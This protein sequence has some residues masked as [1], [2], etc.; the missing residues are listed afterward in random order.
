MA[1]VSMSAACSGVADPMGLQ[2]AAGGDLKTAPDGAMS[3]N[4]SVDAAMV[5]PEAG[6]EGASSTSST[7]TTFADSAATGEG[8]VGDA[9]HGAADATLFGVDSPGAPAADLDASLAASLDAS[10]V[11]EAGD[12]AAQVA[13]ASCFVTFTVA[14]AFIDGVLDTGVAIGGDTTAL[15]NWDSSGAVSMTSLGAGAWTVSLLMNDGDEIQ[16][17]FVKRGPN[18]Y[19][20]EDWG[21]NSNR[22]LVVSC[23]PDVDA[24]APADGGPVVGTSYAGQ[25]GVKPSDAT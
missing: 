24:G 17:L 25:F 18:S 9:A 8:G 22:S 20:W 1:V 3:A 2:A 23:A 16:F 5:S 13:P 6:G 19:A 10:G 21:V 11:G 15:G 12:T 4:G 14:D 7:Q